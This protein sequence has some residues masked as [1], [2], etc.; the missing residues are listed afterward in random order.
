MTV[1][2]NPDATTLRLA[3]PGITSIM[4]DYLQPIVS[5]IV[6]IAFAT[7]AGV[8]QGILFRRKTKTTAQT[9]LENRIAKL[10]TTMSAAAAAVA[11]IQAELAAQ[12]AT[13]KQLAEDVEQGRRLAELNAEAKEAVTAALRQ[14]LAQQGRRAFWQGV[15]INVLFLIAGGAITLAVTLWVH[16][17]S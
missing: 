5:G 10:G 6:G 9:T 16:P 7:Y 12:Q 14:E 1:V 15:G 8:L 11:T 3:V 17:L 4:T 2:P 13:A